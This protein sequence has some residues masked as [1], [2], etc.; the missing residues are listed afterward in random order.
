MTT[1]LFLFTLINGNHCIAWLPNNGTYDFAMYPIVQS[2]DVYP[3]S[4]IDDML[5]DQ[6]FPNIYTVSIN[7]INQTIQ[8]ED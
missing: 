8:C 5:A 7:G 3:E 6:I 4:A 2:V 1:L